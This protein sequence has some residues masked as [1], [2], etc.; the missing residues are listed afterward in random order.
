MTSRPCSTVPTTIA[1]PVADPRVKIFFPNFSQTHTQALAMVA[2]WLGLHPGEV[3]PL[4]RSQLERGLRRKHEKSGGFEVSV[5]RVIAA[6]ATRVF[7]AFS[8]PAAL[9][10]WFTRGARARLAVGGS[11]S[12]HDGDRGRFLALAPAIE[13]ELIEHL[14]RKDRD[15]LACLLA[16]AGVRGSG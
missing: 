6:P 1:V 11:Y 10:R 4:D 5:S 8:R 12:N 13:R 14:A 15:G 3:M 9:S 2:R 7:D 16:R